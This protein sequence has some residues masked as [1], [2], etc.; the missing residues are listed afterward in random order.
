M[1]IGK[2]HLT[3]DPW[4]WLK[5]T[6]LSSTTS[7]LKDGRISIEISSFHSKIYLFKTAKEAD[8]SH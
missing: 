1:F 7:V 5:V 6:S 3:Y 2:G 8:F 4:I